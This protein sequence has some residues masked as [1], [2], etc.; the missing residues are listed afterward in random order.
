MNSARIELKLVLDEAG[1][2]INLDAFSERFN[3]QK[4]VYLIQIMGVDHGYRYAWYL[5]GPYSRAL[6]ADAFTLRD[7]LAAGE[8]DHEK[9]SLVPEVVGRVAK[10]MQLWELP[11]ERRPLRTYSADHTFSPG[12]I[13][14]MLLSHGLRREVD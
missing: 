2:P 13:V 8:R 6:T 12:Q 3:I 7:E 5:R 9:Y 4:R 10:A 1:V 14:L 11:D